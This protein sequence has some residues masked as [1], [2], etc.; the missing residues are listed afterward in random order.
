MRH[1]ILILMI[2]LLPL[3][4][5]AA[6]GMTVRM[7]AQQL[8]TIE[9][10]AAQALSTRSSGLFDAEIRAGMP[11]D[12]AMQMT[13][14][15]DDGSVPPGHGCTTCQLCM[16]VVTGYPTLLVTARVLP[17]AVQG[18]NAT[19]FTSAERAPGFKPPIF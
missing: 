9:N 10:V 16:A 12:C 14:A 7:A 4:G 11:A 3:R 5:W 8:V 19:R 13:P 18:L 15:S 2:A 1:L 6:D 17:Q